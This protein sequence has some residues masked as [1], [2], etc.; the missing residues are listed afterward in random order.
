MSICAEIIDAIC[1]DDGTVD[2]LLGPIGDEGPGQKVLT[3]INPPEDRQGF[4]KAI[5]FQKIWGSENQI[6]VGETKWAD[7]EGYT[8]IRLVE[9]VV[10]TKDY[11]S[12]A[13]IKCDMDD[14]PCA[15][16]AWH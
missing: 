11:G 9:R 10:A 4:C 15:C 2:L 3:V 12:N 6:M 7:R 5:A 1:N 8:R 14:G 13:G 16:G